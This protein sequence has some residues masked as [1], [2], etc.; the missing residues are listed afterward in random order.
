MNDEEKQRLLS[1]AIQT[2]LLRALA[3]YARKT[4]PPL[5]LASVKAKEELLSEV[6]S[7]G[8]GKAGEERLLCELVEVIAKILTGEV[9]LDSAL[10]SFGYISD[11]EHKAFESGTQIGKKISRTSQARK[12]G[13]AKARK[14]ESLK[15]KAFELV[16]RGNYPSKLAASKQIAD[17]IVELSRN[18]NCQMAP[19]NAQRAIYE[20]LLERDKQK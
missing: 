13:N 6:K 14:Y 3:T 17:Q 20:W 16:D 15:T 1:A 11:V 10:A 8:Y 2:G 9:T 5:G 4:T 7:A 19:S 18:S 12:G